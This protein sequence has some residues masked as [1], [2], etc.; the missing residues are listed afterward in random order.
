MLANRALFILVRFVCVRPL[1]AAAEN[2]VDI[3][4]VLHRLGQRLLIISRPA[5]DDFRSQPLIGIGIVNGGPLAF[6][7]HRP[8]RQQTE[9]LICSTADK[10]RG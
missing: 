10:T 1:T 5:A 2:A 8:R 4:P 7:L 9:R 6:L 3:Q